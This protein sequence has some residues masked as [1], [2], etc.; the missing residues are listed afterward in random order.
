M[1]LDP[2]NHVASWFQKDW[3]P[4]LDSNQEPIGSA[5]I[6]NLDQ[7]RASRLHSQIGKQVA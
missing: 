4:G 7:F 6:Q 2:L 5:N 1:T 3:L